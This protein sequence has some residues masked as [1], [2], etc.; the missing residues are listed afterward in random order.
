MEGL[1]WLVAVVAWMS[2]DKSERLREKFDIYPISNR[3][4]RVGVAR[5]S[6]C[7]LLDAEARGSVEHITNHCISDAHYS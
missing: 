5:S 1:T 6:R 2:W 3:Q 7:R 4:A